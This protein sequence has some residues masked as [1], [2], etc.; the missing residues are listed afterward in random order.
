MIQTRANTARNC[1]NIL[2]RWWRFSAIAVI[3]L[4]FLYSLGKKTVVKGLLYFRDNAFSQRP[5]NLFQQS[6][7]TGGGVVSFHTPPS[8][9]PQ[10]S[11]GQISRVGSV[12]TPTGPPLMFSTPVFT[13]SS[14][15]AI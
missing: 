1:K 2:G 10:R 5:T 3:P 8:L 13:Q 4:P 6:T 15:A 12:Q 14:G 11:V 9:P 7:N